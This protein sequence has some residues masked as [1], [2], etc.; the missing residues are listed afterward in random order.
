MRRDADHCEFGVSD[1]ERAQGVVEDGVDDSE[2]RV[3]LLRSH[4][5][6]IERNG[7]AQPIDSTLLHGGAALLL[8]EIEPSTTSVAPVA[9]GLGSVTI[10]R[11]VLVTTGSTF[12]LL[13][14]VLG[15]ELGYSEEWSQTRPARN[16]L[17]RDALRVTRVVQ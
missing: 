10:R 16:F 17:C 2:F 1:S 12:V 3:L 8:L 7:R 4:E 13:V 9:S 15:F 6:W 11:F 14:A 5:S